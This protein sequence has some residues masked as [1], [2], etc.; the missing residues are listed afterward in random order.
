MCMAATATT[1]ESVFTISREGVQDAP[2][3]PAPLQP[4]VRALQR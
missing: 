4:L 3:S 2:L 1:T